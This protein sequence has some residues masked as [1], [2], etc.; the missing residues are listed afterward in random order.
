M[1]G[2]PGHFS[3][4]YARTC[5]VDFGHLTKRYARTRHG[6]WQFA[7]DYARVRHGVGHLVRIARARVLEFS[8]LEVER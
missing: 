1:T 3:D 5:V 6:V 8:I 7:K 4:Q 2:G